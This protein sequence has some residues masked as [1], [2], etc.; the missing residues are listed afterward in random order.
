MRRLVK[1]PPLLIPLLVAAALAFAFLLTMGHEAP[2]LA[3]SNSVPVQGAVV[4]IGHR[5][6]VC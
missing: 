1:F 3:D 5:S 6:R 4:Q 2:R